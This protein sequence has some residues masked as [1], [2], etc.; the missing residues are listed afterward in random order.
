MLITIDINLAT[1][2]VNFIKKRPFIPDDVENSIVARQK[3]F[4]IKSLLGRKIDIDRFDEIFKK[5]EK[6]YF[7]MIFQPGETVGIICGQCIGEKTTQSSLNNFHSAGLDTGILSTIDHLQNV[8][9]SSKCNKKKK[10][11]NL[12]L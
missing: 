1:K 6:T 11:V 7:L 3:N 12:L 9:N 5:L 4:F 10:L 2:L 8:I